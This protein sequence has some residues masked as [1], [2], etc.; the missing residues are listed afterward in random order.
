M[1]LLVSMLVFAFVGCS[2]SPDAQTTAKAAQSAAASTRTTRTPIRTWFDPNTARDLMTW[3]R[4]FD[5]AEAQAVADFD[6][7]RQ[8]TQGTPDFES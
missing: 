2:P 1:H 3:R 6:L 4:E 8:R 5:A 7:L